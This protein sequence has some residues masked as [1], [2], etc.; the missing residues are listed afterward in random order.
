M[1]VLGE[2]DEPW[3]LVSGDGRILRNKAERSV[4]QS[5]GLPFF[6]LAPGWL[7]MKLPEYAWKFVKV[8]PSIVEHAQHHRGRIFVVN[9]GHSSKVEPLRS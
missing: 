7:K 3:V 9:A 5:T 6:C 4:L 1:H 2:D 8:W